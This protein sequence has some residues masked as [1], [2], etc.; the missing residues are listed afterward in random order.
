MKQ[1]NEPWI[2]DDSNPISFA[3]LVPLSVFGADLLECTSNYTLHYIYRSGLETRCIVSTCFFCIPVCL[4]FVKTF[5]SVE[6]RDLKQ[7][8]ELQ[9]QLFPV[10]YSASFYTKL[11]TANC[12]SIIAVTG[13]DTIG[14]GKDAL[15][16]SAC[17][18][19]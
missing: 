12:Y 7:L 4:T 17:S 2:S 8:E 19:W 16:R 15:S 5:R 1:S 6:M 9:K 10:Q 3:N 18:R 11:L 14:E 13:T